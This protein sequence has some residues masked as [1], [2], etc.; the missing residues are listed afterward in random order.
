LEGSI[1]LIPFLSFVLKNQNRTISQSHCNQAGLQRKESQ[2]KK[3]LQRN[4][5]RIC[6]S[7]FSNGKTRLQDFKVE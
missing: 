3:T 1:S 6:F 2:K 5:L 7:T 4:F